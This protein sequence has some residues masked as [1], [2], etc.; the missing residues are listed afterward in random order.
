MI[1]LKAYSSKFHVIQPITPVKRSAL[2]L[3]QPLAIA[4]LFFSYFICRVFF[5]QLT[6]AKSAFI[7]PTGIIVE[8]FYDAGSYIGGEWIYEIGSTQF[9]LGESC[10]GTTFF[11]L[12][13]AYFIYR[14]LTLNSSYVWL[15]LAYPI[16][17][18]AN[19]MR[20]LSSISAHNLLAVLDASAYRDE[21]HAIT[22]AIAFLTCFLLVAMF[23]ESNPRTA[24]K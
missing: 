8:W 2:H 22:G 11:S 16:T 21:V 14:S 18:F 9:I 10:S 23:I 3:S 1:R 6:V 4:A 15:L 24:I 19:A 17:I 13:V 7:F 12:L 20:V 5:Q